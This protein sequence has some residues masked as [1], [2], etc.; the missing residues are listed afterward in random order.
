MFIQMLLTADTQYYGALQGNIT[1]W[2][3][4][5]CNDTDPGVCSWPW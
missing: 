4:I 5:L 1:E 3:S 2:T